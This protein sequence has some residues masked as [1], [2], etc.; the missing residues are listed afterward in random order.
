MGGGEDGREGLIIMVARQL[1]LKKLNNNS[2]DTGQK[3][4]CNDAMIMIDFT[5]LTLQ[6]LYRKRRIKKTN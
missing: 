4:N 6:R 2:N 5:M 1:V 3:R